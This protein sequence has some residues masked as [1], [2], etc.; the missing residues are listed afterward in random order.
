[1][2]RLGRHDEARAD[3]AL[4]RQPGDELVGEVLA[5][6]HERVELHD[7]VVEGLLD[8]PLGRRLGPTGGAVV[9][10][11]GEAVGMAPERPEAGEDVALGQRGEVAQAGQTEAG[12]QADELGVDLA[13]DVQPG[14]GQRGE[15]VGRGA[16]RDDDRRPAGPP[17]RD[18]RGEAPVGDA[19]ADPGRHRPGLA[20][21]GGDEP[22]G[23]R[24]VAAEV[25]RRTTG[26][27]AQPARLDDV[28]ARGEAADR[29]HHGFERP[30]IAVGVVVEQGDVRAA[31]LGLAA[32]L[33]DGHALRRGRR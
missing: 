30:G 5:G 16:R 12:E 26:A 21:H 22:A 20:P 10:T 9:E 23:Q 7:R 32:A 29:P 15:E 28:E 19:H 1:V 17:G 6:E 4:R 13:D 2:L 14:H 27:E 11:G 24:L 25:A 33:A 18:G 8:A 31:L 3:P